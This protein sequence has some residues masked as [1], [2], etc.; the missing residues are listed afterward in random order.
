MSQF[1]HLVFTF[2]PINVSLWLVTVFPISEYLIACVWTKY[3]EI[4]LQL[5]SNLSS[6]TNSWAV[7]CLVF[8]V[9]VRG[10][11]S[12]CATNG[13]NRKTTHDLIS[14][15]WCNEIRICI[16][17]LYFISN[18]LRS[19][20]PTMYARACVWLARS[21]VPSW[22]YFCKII[23]LIWSLCLAANEWML[24]RRRCW[25]WPNKFVWAKFSTQ[26]VLCEISTKL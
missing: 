8:G 5:Q 24:Y 22:M 3:F 25:R 10:V 1:S 14:T 15:C 7:Y 23:I 20:Q 17:F 4:K 19:V 6:I 11:T 18:K 13:E 9:T 12:L 26:P 16:R 21:H 2:R